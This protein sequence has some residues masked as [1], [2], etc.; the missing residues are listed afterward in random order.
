M[1]SLLLTLNRCHTLFWCFFSWLWANKCRM[2]GFFETWHIMSILTHMGHVLL[3]KSNILHSIH[4]N[5]ELVPWFGTHQPQVRLT[6]LKNGKR[7]LPCRL[8]CW[9]WKHFTARCTFFLPAIAFS[10]SINEMSG[11][12]AN[13]FLFKVNNANSRKRC[14]ICSELTIKTPERCNWRRSGIFIVN[15]IHFS[16]LFLVFLFSTLNK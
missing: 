6:T 5:R 9:L 8:N 12:P 2:R 4:L 14:E 10:G 3:I 16:H 11:I 15:S 13:I 7:S 1:V